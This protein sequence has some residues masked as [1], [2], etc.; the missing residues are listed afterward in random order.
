MNE[1]FEFDELHGLLIAMTANQCCEEMDNALVDTLNKSNLP[2]SLGL[3]AAIY[4]VA[5]LAAS[6]INAINEDINASD[7]EYL[8]TQFLEMFE[9]RFD[10]AVTKNITLYA[11]WEEYTGPEFTTTVTV[12]PA[13]TD[14]TAGKS[15]T[16]VLFGDWPQTIK[17]S[18]VIVDESVNEVHGRFTYYRGSDGYWYVKCIEN[19]CDLTYKYS[20]GTP[21]NQSSENSIKYFKVEPIKWRVLT[22]DYNGTENALLLAENI[23]TASV[24]FFD[25]CDVNRINNS[26]TVYPNN[27]KKSKI[28]AYLNGYNYVVKSSSGSDM[29]DYT[30]SNKGFFQSA[31]TPD[32]QTLIATSIVD[33]S[34]ASTTDSANNLS[35][36]ISYYCA[37]TSDKIFLLSEKEVTTS[38]YGFASYNSDGLGNT[39]IRET[40][41]YAKANYAYQNSTTGYGGWWWLRSPVYNDS[42]RVRDIYGNGDTRSIHNV[43]NT[44][45]GIV[46]ALTIS[47]PQN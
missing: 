46:P 11:K 34:A 22:A 9:T 10:A 26:S 39:R 47:L 24:E 37:N 8:K 2:K 42:N 25:Y 12:L 7:K 40:T 28:R 30:Y 19:A 27:Y 18:D 13:G 5:T 29:T 4:A 38:S 41:D 32:A 17:T 33:N 14:G 16:Y 20:D 21:V 23:L 15:A 31:F 43:G 45:G 36:A 6:V 1:K 35:Q 3:T 44:N